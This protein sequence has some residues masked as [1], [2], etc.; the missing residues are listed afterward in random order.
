VIHQTSGG[1]A[2]RGGGIDFRHL[3]AYFCRIEFPKPKR[4]EAK[5]NTTAMRWYLTKIR[6]MRF[7]AAATAA[8]LLALSFGAQAQFPQQQPNIVQKAQT[9]VRPEM[10]PIPACGCPPTVDFQ[11]TVA[12][13]QPDI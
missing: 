12:P 7:L 6:P 8:F 13:G 4:R 10:R 11:L 9:G 1:P 3:L 5:M 2:D